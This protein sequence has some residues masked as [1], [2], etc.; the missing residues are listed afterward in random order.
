MISRVGWVVWPVN[1]VPPTA[2]T[3]G[4][5]DGYSTSGTPTGVPVLSSNEQAD[6]SSPPGRGLQE[7]TEVTQFASSFLQTANRSKHLP[8]RA[9]GGDSSDS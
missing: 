6:P 5:D 7:A 3:W 4:D 8:S 2:T 9:R 1:V